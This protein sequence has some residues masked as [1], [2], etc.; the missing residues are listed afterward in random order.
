MPQNNPMELKKI[1]PDLKR[2]LAKAGLT[3]ANELEQAVFPVLKSGADCC[4]LAPA[5]SGKSTAL[6]MGIIQRLERPVGES[7]RALVLVNSREEVQAFVALLNQL[8]Q[9]TGLRVL[10]THD[11]GDI[12]YDKNVISL[13]L[14]ILV[15]TPTRINAVFSSAGFNINTVKIFAIDNADV[16]FKNRHDAVVL[17]LF[18]SINKTQRIFT[19]T[20]DTERVEIMADKVMVEPQWFSFYDE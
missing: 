20:D 15:G 14:D 2:A 18:S 8:S 12:D 16:I 1:N 11:K 13:G 6:A 7:T 17:R 3:E 19:M 5:G 9:Y 4:I 10:G